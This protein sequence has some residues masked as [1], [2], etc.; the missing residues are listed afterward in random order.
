MIN[1]LSN[2]NKDDIRAARAN[3]FILR[4]TAIVLIAFLF[5]SAALY[6]SYTVLGN[7]MRSADELIASNDVKAD[8]YSETKQQVDA[9]SGKLTEA[10]SILDQEVRYSE[11][12]VKI[13]QLLPAGTVLG[14]LTLTSVHFSGTALD[15]TAYAKSTE[16]ASQVQTR[17]QN[18]PLFSNVS[19]KSTDTAQ[20]IAGYPVTV[21]LSVTLNRAGL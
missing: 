21:S 2:D 5:I 11:V 20:G 9:L 18:S 8:V 16:E 12:L 6:T 10:K 15:I 17:F 7:T 14:N 13:G 4:Y 19:L 1:L 3:V